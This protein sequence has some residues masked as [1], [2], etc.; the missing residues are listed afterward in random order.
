MQKLFYEVNS[1]DKKCYDKFGLSEDILME[2][3]SLSMASFIENNFKEQSSVLIVCGSGNNGADGIALAR[4]LFGKYQVFLYTPYGVKSSMA[5]LQLKRVNNMGLKSIE[6]PLPCD[7]I[8]DCIFGT[9]LNKILDDFSIKL[10]QKLNTFKGYKIACDIPSGINKEGQLLPICFNANTTITMGALKSAL[11]ADYVKDS[12]GKIEVATLG[13]PS[14]LYEEESNIF[15]LDS[16][17]MEIPFRLKNST[18]KG[19]FGHLSVIVGEK[20]GQESL[21]VKLLLILDVPL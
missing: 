8:V 13:V 9:G 16:S 3:A 7:V 10:I 4:L 14:F 6:Q 15:L 12:V 21:L 2:H 1:L 11:Y 5:Q 17:D 19:D 18:H 20:K